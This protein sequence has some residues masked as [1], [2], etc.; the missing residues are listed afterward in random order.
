MFVTQL[1]YLGPRIVNVRAMATLSWADEKILRLTEVT[2][3]VESTLIKNSGIDLPAPPPHD[4]NL[5]S[6]AEWLIESRPT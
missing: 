1:L 4:D 5:Q 2:T 3:V 6:R